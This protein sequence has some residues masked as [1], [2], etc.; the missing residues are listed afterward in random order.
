MLFAALAAFLAAPGPLNAAQNPLPRVA[1]I[2]AADALVQAEVHSGRLASAQLAVLFQSRI[3]RKNYG[4]ATDRTVYE[5]ASL[6]KPVATATAVMILVDRGRLALRD[7]VAKYIPEFAQNGKQDVTIQDLLLHTSGLAASF[8]ESDYSADRA[9]ILQHAYALPLDYGPGTGFSY[10]NLGFIILAEVVGR[11]SGMPFEDFCARNIFKPL[12]MNDSFFDTTIDAAHRANVAPQL[13]NQS[14]QLLRQTFG[15]VPGVNGHAGMLSNAADLMKFVLALYSTMLP[16]AFPSEPRIVSNRALTAM[17]AP[18]YVG[19]G[20]F[21]GLGWD[22]ASDFSRNGGDLM[23]RGSFGHTGSSGTSLWMDPATGVA[24]IL[25]TNNHYT[26]D[27][28]DTVGLAGRIANILEAADAVYSLQDV[29][30]Q[31]LRFD[32]A[33]ARS[34][35]GFPSTPLPAP[36][37]R[38][39]PTPKGS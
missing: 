24:V 12:A 4:A 28:S 32:A 35:A 26:K 25:V 5:L 36:T 7:R 15:T 20:A 31:E 14:E 8:P 39:A 17:I 29:Q 34:A 27:A 30:M 10:S 21:R 16:S 22:L 37:P 23:P 6:T 38:P 3:F 18:H 9:T 13:A 33:A 1:A 11:V 2:D 19:D